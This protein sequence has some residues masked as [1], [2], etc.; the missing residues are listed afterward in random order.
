MHYMR[1]RCLSLPESIPDVF[2]F[3]LLPPPPLPSQMYGRSMT[4]LFDNKM[5]GKW[6]FFMQSKLSKRSKHADTRACARAHIGM[7]VAACVSVVFR[8]CYSGDG[9]N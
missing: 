5:K 2:F 1:K 7:R 6:V 3:F 9:S 4:A 8:Q